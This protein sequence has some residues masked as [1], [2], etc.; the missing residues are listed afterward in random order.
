MSKNKTYTVQFKRKRNQKTDY[1]K[2]LKYLKSEKTRIIIRS[3]IN[4]ILIQAIEFNESGDKILASL[5]SK[6][7]KKLGWDY[8]LGNLPSAYLT[9]LYF[10]IKNKE[11]LKEGIIDLG[12]KSIT[13]G[14]RLSATIK[15]LVDSE[16]KIPHSDKLFPKEEQINGLVI[17]KYAKSISENKE[18]YEKQFSKYLKNNVNPENITKDFEKIKELILKNEKTSKT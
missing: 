16:L 9:G 1:K 4:N 14:D 2:R 17:T 12:L 13:K 6:D 10:G 7:L 3:S 5:S 15:G 8:H 18:K 11:K